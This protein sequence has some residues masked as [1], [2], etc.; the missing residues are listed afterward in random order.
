MKIGRQHDPSQPRLGIAALRA[1]FAAR[2]L[3]VTDH[4]AATLAAIAARNAGMAVYL[5]LDEARA[6]A[7]AQASD[8]RHAAGA[9]LS[10]LDGIILAVKDNIDV[11]GMPTTAGLGFRRGRTAAQDAFVVARLRAAGAIVLGKVNMHAAA[12]GATNRNADFGDCGNPAHPGRVA[13]GSSGGSAAAVAAGWAQLA[14]GT[15]T[16]GSVRIPASYCG[17]AGIKP[18]AGLVS[19]GGVVP[20]CTRLDHVGLLAGGAQDLA[21]AL[22]LAAGFDAADPASRVFGAFPSAPP[23]ARVRAPRDAMATIVEPGIWDRFEAALEVVHG[24]GC[25]V[26]RFDAPAF[27][28]GSLRRAGLLLTGA[29]MLVTYDTEWRTR[30]EVLPAEMVATMAWAEGKSARDM[31][32][33][34][35]SLAEGITLLRRLQGDAPCL[36]LPSAAQVPF[37]V[38]APAPANQADFTVLANIGGAP[39]VSVPMPCALDEHAAGL[40]IVAASGEDMLALALAAAYEAA[41]AA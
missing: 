4:L 19:C 26:E 16:M 32:R 6:Q 35:A 2:T 11:A 30:R 22:P 12:F 24:L 7:A 40:Q 20:L 27:D 15:D 10:V 31:A 3:K 28:L 41:H 14:L 21:A 36:L 17:I 8:A 39:A 1:H 25:T 33:A 9:P 23:P 29:E 38:E 37:A 5:A 18:S 34:L 13:G